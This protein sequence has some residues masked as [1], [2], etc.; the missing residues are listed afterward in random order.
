DPQVADNGKDGNKPNVVPK[1][2]DD[3]DDDDLRSKIQD[4][5][6]K[7]LE[8][9]TVLKPGIGDP[10]ADPFSSISLNKQPV[11]GLDQQKINAAIEKGVA[12]LK[13]T[14]NANGTWHNGHGVGHAS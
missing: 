7:V 12:Y 14:Q 5:V 10:G 13:R 9:K 11:P 3:D 8:R 4:E 2:G 6:K 1:K